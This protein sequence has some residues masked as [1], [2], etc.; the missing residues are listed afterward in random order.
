MTEKNDLSFGLFVRY[1]G[2]IIGLSTV[3]LLTRP[4]FL[5]ITINWVF[6]CLTSTKSNFRLGFLGS[7]LSTW[8]SVFYS[9][10][11]YCAVFVRTPQTSEPRLQVLLQ[12]QR[13][14]NE[15][16][17]EYWRSRNPTSEKVLEL[18]NS[19]EEAQRLLLRKGPDIAKAHFQQIAQL[20]TSADWKVPEREIIFQSI[21]RAASF[22]KDATLRRKYFAEATSLDDSMN[23]DAEIFDPLFVKEYESFRSEYLTRSQI[24]RPRLSQEVEIYVNGKRSPNPEK[25][26]L[27]PGIKRITIVGNATLP[28]TMLLD[29]GSLQKNPIHLEALVTGNCG[30]LTWGYRGD[31]KNN[32]VAVLESDCMGDGKAPLGIRGNES[33]GLPPRQ[34]E[35]NFPTEIK[36]ESIVKK[37]LF[38]IVTGAV[39]TAAVIIIKNQNQQSNSP[40]PTHSEGL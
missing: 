21:L 24:W 38:W 37:P 6:R 16:F 1:I 36:N 35:L 40:A 32:F 9:S 17:V 26:R 5:G 33:V 20:T 4:S 7:F 15:S 23:A 29:I 27:S 28:H 34:N 12:K 11:G 22:E 2:S 25:L 8:L 18:R 31:D 39:I 10:S 13:S 3:G 14:G 30:N 19:F